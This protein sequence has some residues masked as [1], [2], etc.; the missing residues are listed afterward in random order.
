MRE[1][2]HKRLPVKF[3]EE[4][5]ESFNGHRPFVESSTLPSW[6]RRPRKDFIIPF[7]AIASDSLP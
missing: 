4:V 7:A 5:L 2:I 6:P 1:R 3:V